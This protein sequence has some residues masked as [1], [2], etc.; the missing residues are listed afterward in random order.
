MN[1]GNKAELW[2]IKALQKLPRMNTIEYAW[3]NGKPEVAW[4]RSPAETP[5]TSA[6]GREKLTEPCLWGGHKHHA[7]Q[8]IALLEAASQSCQNL[9][10]IK[11]VFPQWS[12]FERPDQLRAMLR[13][14]KNV[15]HLYFTE[16]S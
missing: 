2:L 7:K 6:I 1:T 15:Q 16:I 8:F 3:R 13:A 10:T 5:R 9:T 14:M 11:G 4:S 12:I